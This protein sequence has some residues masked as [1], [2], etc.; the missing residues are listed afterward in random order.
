MQVKITDDA[1]VE[2]MVGNFSRLCEIWD[3]ARAQASRDTDRG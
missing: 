3:A 1:A 2:T